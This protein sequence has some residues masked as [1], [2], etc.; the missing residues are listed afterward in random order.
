MKNQRQINKELRYYNRK[1]YYLLFLCLFLSELLITAY[2][3]MMQSPTVLTI[4]P[5]GGDSRKQVSMI[6]FLAVFGCGVFVV[7]AAALFL[8]YKSRETGIFMALG[9]SARQLGARLL[10]ELLLVS[11]ISFLG[12]MVLGTPLA[13]CIWKLFCIF[14]VNTDETSFSIGVQAYG[15]SVCYA[16]VCM[17][18]LIFMGILFIRQTD[19]IAIVHNERKCEPVRDVKPWYG[20]AGI[21]LM[22]LGGSLR[23]YDADALSPPAELVL[24]GVDQCDLSSLVCR[25]LHASSVYCCPWKKKREEALAGYYYRQHDEVPGAADGEQHAGNNGFACRRVFCGVL[26]ANDAVW[27]AESH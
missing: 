22:I 1:N 6:F 26:Y 20:W 12:G 14:L 4:L 19:V 15:I 21:L 23:I 24:P 3:V 18:L 10:R 13:F 27:L 5:E 16:L 17:V 2:A 7:Y 8:K 9:A 11:G 25:A